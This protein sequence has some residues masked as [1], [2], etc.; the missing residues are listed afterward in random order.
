LGVVGRLTVRWL[1]GGPTALRPVSSVV[2]SIKL[3]FLHVSVRI[4]ILISIGFVMLIEFSVANFRSICERQALSLVAG[5]GPEHRD[6]HVFD[7][8]APSTPA[9]LRSAVIYGPN[10]AGK[11]NLIMALRFVADF[12]RDSASATMPGDKIEVVPF[13]MSADEGP[14]PSEFELNFV[15]E[16]VRYQYGFAVTEQRIE[17]EWLLAFPEGRPQRWFERTAKEAKWYFGPNFQGQKKLWQDATRAN[18]LF[19]S[20]AVQFNAEQLLPVFNWIRHTLRVINPYARVSPGFSIEQ[21]RK[22]EASKLRIAQFMGAADLGITDVQVRTSTFD[23]AEVPED[24][25]LREY[26]ITKMAGKE[27]AEVQFS[28]GV[29]GRSVTL[30]MEDESGGTQKLFALA[31]PWFD[32]L[33]H[34]LVLFVDELDT[35]LHP[36]LMR[37][38]VA[39]F[40]D[41]ATNRHHAQLIFSTHD[42]SILD[43][44]VFRRDQ[45]WFM[46][47]DREHQSRLYPL[48]DFSPRKEGNLERGYLQ[49]RYGA[50][51]FIGELRI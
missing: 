23:P 42:T 45:I 32:V 9:L 36:L 3:Q 12:V 39:L 41:P 10:A 5:V 50:L 7:P 4:K 15:Q 27:V 8:A 44:D 40:N 49:G 46:Q 20:T 37:H 26:I 22:D 11:S 34:G 48:T 31:G 17:S 30:D 2:S 29:E 6:S 1:L 33:D 28:H 14:S 16:G 18:A 24:E 13:A 25:P 19:L 47:K 51:P 21:C 38:L 35:S 43:H